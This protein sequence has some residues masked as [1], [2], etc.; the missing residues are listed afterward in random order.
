LKLVRTDKHS[1]NHT[2]A[3]EI[4][5]DHYTS[6]SSD[7]IDPVTISSPSHADT[8][9]YPSIDYTVQNPVNNFSF[10]GSLSFST[11]F[12]YKSFGAGF[13]IELVEREALLIE[14]REIPIVRH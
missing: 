6:A 9:I 10:G 13:H 3:G 14:S 11:E 4:G 5:I 2:L 12:D 1:R 8:R 7:K